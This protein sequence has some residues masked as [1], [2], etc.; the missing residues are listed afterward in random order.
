MSEATRK[1][2]LERDASGNPSFQYTRHEN[3]DITILFRRVR[4]QM[5][6]PATANVRPIKG[7]KA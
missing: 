7:R 6:K 2:L 3:T 4:E 1:R 5:A